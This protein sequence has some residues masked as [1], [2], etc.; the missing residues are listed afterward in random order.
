MSGWRRDFA[1]IRVE[2]LVRRH[3]LRIREAHAPL[4]AQRTDPHT[5]VTTG[6][7]IAANFVLYGFPLQAATCSDGG[8]FAFGSCARSRRCL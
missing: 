5:R 8:S 6:T 3:A 7:R 4:T 2:C 1:K